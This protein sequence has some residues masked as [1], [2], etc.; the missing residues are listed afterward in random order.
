M[1]GPILNATSNVKAVSSS[2][3]ETAAALNPEFLINT[4]DSFYFCGIQNTSDPQIEGDWIE[5]FMSKPTLG[6]LEWYSVLGNHEYGYVPQ[7]V[8][9]LAKVQ[10]KWVMDA[11][12]YSRRMHLSPS[13]GLTMIFLDT[14]PCVL[15]YQ[16]SNAAGWDPCGTQYP[17]CNGPN[18]GPCHFH[19]NILETKCAPQQAW[20]QKTLDAVPS[21][22]W[23]IIVGHHA[24]YEVT[25][26]DLTG[27]LQGYPV[28]MY[29]NGH[30]HQL[31]EYKLDGKGTYI[32]TG[33]G[34]LA[35][36]PARAAKAG[37]EAEV[38]EE[39]E[40]HRPAADSSHTL[41][42][43]WSQ[44]VAGYST[45][46]FSSELKSLTTKFYNSNGEMIHSLVSYR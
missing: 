32:T 25:E 40:T 31:V 28:S 36:Q 13:I 16:S 17:I 10:D 39:D 41:S 22:D 26:F 34:S 12:Y 38:E 46:T 23:L 30:D 7:A 45:H 1:V 18:E 3:E 44:T 33:A 27:M 37:M 5:P 15:A 2:F 24:V 14:N 11:R 43:V 29:I 42:T 8:V 19:E 4:G 6:S 20:L 21:G 35:P 9:D